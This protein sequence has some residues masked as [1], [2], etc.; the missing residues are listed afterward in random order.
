M[1]TVKQYASNL[2]KVHASVLRKLGVDTAW[3]AAGKRAP[4]LS[5]DVMLAGLIKALTDKGVLTDTDVN[6]VFTSIT[7]A[8]F[9]SLPANVP[10]P[11]GDDQTMPDPDLGP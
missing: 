7:N 10:A 11:V 9:P 3:G 4:I 8:A 5:T 6:T 1:A 2:W